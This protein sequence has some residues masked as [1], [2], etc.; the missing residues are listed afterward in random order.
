VSKFAH[1]YEG[2]IPNVIISY[3]NKSFQLNLLIDFH[4]TG[5]LMLPYSICEQLNL[6]TI[7]GSQ[8]FT[9]HDSLVTCCIQMD[10]GSCRCEQLNVISRTKVNTNNSSI[11]TPDDHLNNIGFH[12][13]RYTCSKYSTLTK[14]IMPAPVTFEPTV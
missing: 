14:K 8:F 3:N 13:D 12:H 4:Y 5:D 11:Y 1:P 2:I 9:V 10:D 7:Y 6:K